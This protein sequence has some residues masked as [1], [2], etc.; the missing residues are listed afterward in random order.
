MT[1]DPVSS[2][3]FVPG[4]RAGGSGLAIVI[5]FCNNAIRGPR[6]GEFWTLD[7]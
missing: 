5:L 3:R 1:I 4:S 2:T 6:D 7:L